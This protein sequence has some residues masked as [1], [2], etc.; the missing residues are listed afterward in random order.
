MRKFIIFAALGAAASIAAS[1]DVRAADAV[2]KFDIAKI[3]KAETAETVGIGET[4]ASCTKAEE[5][6]RTQ[7]AGQW[8]KFTAKDK[9]ACISESS[10]D[11]TPSYVELQTC[12][13]MAADAHAT[14]AARK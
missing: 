14:T 6:A 11:G 10:I 5:Q 8:S 12:L 3:C 2:P 4:L 7:V 1:H 13:E 9:A